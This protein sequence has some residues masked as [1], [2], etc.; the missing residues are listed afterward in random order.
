MPG[1]LVPAMRAQVCANTLWGDTA[2]LCRVSGAESTWHQREMFDARVGADKPKS[3]SNIA[4]RCYAAATLVRG[5]CAPS[6]AAL[7][8]PACAHNLLITSPCIASGRASLLRS[9]AAR[10]WAH[11]GSPAPWVPHAGESCCWWSV[12]PAAQQWLAQHPTCSPVLRHPCLP[13]PINRISPAL[14]RGPRPGFRMRCAG[15][16]ETNGLDVCIVVE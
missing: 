6:D 8:K 10:L 12:G 7:I 3:N 2:P 9:K 4:S 14:S 16:P 5:M 1:A 13:S 11:Q 15:R